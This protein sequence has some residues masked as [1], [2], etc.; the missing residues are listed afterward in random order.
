[1]A[2]DTIAQEP[3]EAP[4]TETPDAGANADLPVTGTLGI[5]RWI[6]FAYITFALALFWLYDHLIVATWEIFADSDGTIASAGAAILALVT[7]LVAYRHPKASKFSNE[8]AEEL[9]KVVW[10]SREET[11]QQTLVVL[12]LSAIAAIIFGIFDF[13]WMKLSDLIYTL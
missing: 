6:Q 4:A 9:S 7:A 5:E 13:T 2:E 10:P 1:M 12:A 11:W 3:G 8:V